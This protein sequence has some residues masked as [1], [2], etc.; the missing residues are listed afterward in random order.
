[1]VSSASSVIIAMVLTKYRRPGDLDQAFLPFLNGTG[2]ETG[3]SDPVFRAKFEETTGTRVDDN[4]I[5]AAQACMRL[6]TGQNHTWKEVAFLRQ[7]W[8]GP[9]ILKGIQHVDDAKAAL[10]YG[11]DGIVVSNH[12]GMSTVSAGSDLHVTLDQANLAGRQLDGAIGSLEVLPEIVDAVGSQMTVLFDSGIRTGS[13]IIKALAL[14][15]KAV[16][17]GR[18]VMYGYAV[19]G[20]DGAKAVLQGLLADL[21]LSMGLV[22]LKT[23]GHCRR[24]AIRKV[25]YGGDLKAVL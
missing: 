13:D 23:V 11:C 25:T 1:M 15:A 2:T 9:L 19:N 7:N 24:D 18:P 16:F 20:T 4:K 17:I 10:S 21:Y 22:G 6:L 5:V 3:L 8:D 14:G 12:G